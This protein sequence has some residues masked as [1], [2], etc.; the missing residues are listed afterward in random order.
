MNAFLA[1]I[2]RQQRQQDAK[3]LSLITLASRGDPKQVDKIL[4]RL[5]GLL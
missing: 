3:W 2:E 5:S 1:A 4:D